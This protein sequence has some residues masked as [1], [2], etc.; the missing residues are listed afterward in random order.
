M[1]RRHVTGVASHVTIS[2]RV[3]ILRTDVSANPNMTQFLRAGQ[4]IHTGT[5]PVY[6]KYWGSDGGIRSNDRC[7]LTLGKYA[8]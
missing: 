8:G 4:W 1:R 2:R 5:K 3:T 7:N 6:K